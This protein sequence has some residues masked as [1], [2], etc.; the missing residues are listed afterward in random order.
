MSSNVAVVGCSAGACLRRR[1]SERLTSR[2][3]L[4]IVVSLSLFF[5]LSFSRRVVAPYTVN[6]NH[7]IRKN[8]YTQRNAC[9]KRARA[10]ASSTFPHTRHGPTL[11]RTPE[12]FLP[13]RISGT[14]EKD[15]PKDSR[16]IVSIG[17]GRDRTVGQWGENATPSA[18]ATFP[19][20]RLFFFEERTARERVAGSR[21]RSP[22]S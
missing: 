13:F 2:A 10:Y 17:T 7:T 3:K 9:R 6:T 22:A 18:E 20:T 1:Q 16:A 14:I 4:E 21:V 19:A 5:S 12:N 8:T 11:V 15:Y